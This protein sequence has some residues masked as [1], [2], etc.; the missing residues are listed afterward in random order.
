M[1]SG[2]KLIDSMRDGKL[3][4]HCV[5]VSIFQKCKS[6]LYLK[7]YGVIKVNQVGTIYLEFICLEA[8]NKHGSIVTGFHESFPD[9]PFNPSQKLFLEATTLSGDQVFAE[10]FS[11]RIS[12]FNRKNPY[13]LHVFLHEIYFFDHNPRH[14]DSENYMYFELMEKP[15]IPTNKMNTES[16][17]YGEESHSWNESEIKVED[18]TITIVDR[19]DRIEVRAKGAFEA[20]ELYQSL[21]FYFGLSSGRMPQP[22]CL[23]KRVSSETTLYL[24]SIRHGLK[25]KTIPAPITDATYGE[26]FPDSHYAIL[27]SILRVKRNN[28]MR[29]NSAFSQWQR[30]WHSFQSENDIATLSL[31]IAVEGLLNDVFIPELKS[32]SINQELENAKIGLIEKLSALHARD[33]HKQTLISGVKR[34]GNIHPAKALTILME[35]GLVLQIE[36]KAWGELRN[37]AAHPV[38]KVNNEASELKERERI[39]NTLTLFYRL[40][41]NIFEYDG[42]MYEFRVNTKPEFFRRTYVQVLDHS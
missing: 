4:L 32:A 38:F 27:A 30:V 22:Y 12:V 11:L 14:L 42:P 34:W 36:K 23:I 41:L 10:E 35:K 21:L 18:T 5:S 1:F 17:T 6:G 16:S 31:G 9:D 8:E 37:S 13:K 28:S 29:F 20:D 39:S 33:D 24:K 2:D 26:G 7:G 15:R 19:N 40:V 3:E 25:G